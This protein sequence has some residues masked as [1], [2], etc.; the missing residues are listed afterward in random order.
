M[1][2]ATEQDL[3]GV[4]HCLR[5]AFE[6]YR[7]SYTP[8]AFLDTVP[9]PDVLRDRLAAMIVLV[10]VP[11]SGDVAGTVAGQRRRDSEGH[12]RGMAVD[13]VWQ[14][15]GIADELLAAIEV[16]L[17]TIGCARVTL[18]TTEPLQKAMRFYGKHGYGPSGR[19]TDFYGMPLHEYVKWLAPR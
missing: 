2:R 16:E 6:P 17:R 18:D 4:A 12:L 15:S 13:P 19:V 11:T 1:R 3:A 10:A 7:L 5:A 9:P 8:D 14:G